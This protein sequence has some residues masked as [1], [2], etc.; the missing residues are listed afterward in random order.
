MKKISFI[1]RNVVAIAICLAV[2]TMLSGC[3]N[4]ND[5]NDNGET[6][7]I[8]A[9][10]YTGTVLGDEHMAPYILYTAANAKVSEEWGNGSGTI[11]GGKLAFTYGKPKNLKSIG[12]SEIIDMH[13]QKYDYGSQLK[14]VTFSDPNAKSDYLRLC[15]ELSVT[16]F[17]TLQKMNHIFQDAPSGSTNTYIDVLNV[18]VDRDVTVN[19]AGGSDAWRHTHEGIHLPLRKGWNEVYVKWVKTEIISGGVANITEVVSWGIGDQ[20]CKW[21]ISD[22]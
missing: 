5:E 4:D 8:N 18:Y 20:G 21:V 9:D 1:L 19:A 11:T 16:F 22:W 17:T 6:F 3:D 2:T 10:V 13:I 12:E 7:T 15:P 14:N